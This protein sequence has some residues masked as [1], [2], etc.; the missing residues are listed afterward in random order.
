MNKTSFYIEFTKALFVKDMTKN[1]QISSVFFSKSLNQ[2]KSEYT[3]IWY[4]ECTTKETS[5]DLK[6]IK[7]VSLSCLAF[8]NSFC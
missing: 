5:I 6:S 1:Q 8:Q 3:Y 4:N 7:L 2:L